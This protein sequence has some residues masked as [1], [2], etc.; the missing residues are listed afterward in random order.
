MGNKRLVCLGDSI[1]EGVGVNIGE[2]YVD[3]LCELLN[4]ETF[5]YGENGAKRLCY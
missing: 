2:R 3:Y 5:G 4:V 1:T